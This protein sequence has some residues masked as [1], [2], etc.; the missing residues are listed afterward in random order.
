MSWRDSLAKLGWD[1]LGWL[2]LDSFLDTSTSNNKHVCCEHTSIHLGPDAVIG[3]MRTST[4]V[5]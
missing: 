5:Q 1:T 4:F 2:A 3:W